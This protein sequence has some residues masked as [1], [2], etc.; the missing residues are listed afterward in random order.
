MEKLNVMN[1]QIGR[2]PAWKKKHYIAI[3]EEEN[4]WYLNRFKN[5]IDY[6]YLK[7]KITEI[8][9]IAAPTAM[10][11]KPI[12][13]ITSNTCYT[14]TNQI[15]CAKTNN[16]IKENTCAFFR[17]HLTS[18]MGVSIMRLSPHFLHKPLLTCGHIKIYTLKCMYRSYC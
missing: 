16:N 8:F 10:P 9:T 15:K 14:I 18:V 2:R 1:S 11:A 4:S 3:W 7:K 5:E 6:I 13:N 12:Y 17:I